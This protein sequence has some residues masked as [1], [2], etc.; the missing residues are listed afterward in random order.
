MKYIPD[1]FDDY[2]KVWCEVTNRFYVNKKLDKRQINQ[3]SD[4]ELADVVDIC[5]N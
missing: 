2:S 3:L 5:T 1:H 4:W